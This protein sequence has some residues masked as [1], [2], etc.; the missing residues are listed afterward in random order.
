MV[1]A[2]FTSNGDGLA[3]KKII[4][5]GLIYFGISSACLRAFYWIV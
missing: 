1:G 5:F 3:L 2:M 4:S